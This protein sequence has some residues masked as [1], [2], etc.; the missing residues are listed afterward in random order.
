MSGDRPPDRLERAART[1]AERKRQGADNPEP[2]LGARLGQIGVL[3]WMVVVPALLALFA[4][5]WLDQRLHSGIFFSAPML[6]LGAGLGFW[7]VW[8]WMHRGL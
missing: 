5:R 6:M 8:K 3:G 2:S 7:S 4:G 1:E